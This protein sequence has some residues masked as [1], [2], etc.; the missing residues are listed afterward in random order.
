MPLSSVLLRGE[1]GRD[2]APTAVYLVATNIIPAFFP[3]VKMGVHWE[4]SK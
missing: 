2:L 1:V 4:A 3:W